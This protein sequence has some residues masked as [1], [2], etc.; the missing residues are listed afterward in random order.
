M[1][2]ENVNLLKLSTLNDI[3]GKNFQKCM[4]S[5]LCCCVNNVKTVNIFSSS[6][7]DFKLIFSF[8]WGLS[9]VETDRN[10]NNVFSKFIN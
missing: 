3:L 7:Y 9:V 2:L 5:H 4:S 1:S 6:R 8:Q 10:Y